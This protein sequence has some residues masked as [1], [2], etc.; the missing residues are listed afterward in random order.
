M[1]QVTGSS[2]VPRKDVV[3]GKDVVIGK[4]V[5]SN[6]A[7]FVAKEVKKPLEGSTSSLLGKQVPWHLKA[8]LKASDPVLELPKG[9]AKAVALPPTEEPAEQPKEEQPTIVSSEFNSKGNLVLTFSD[10]K[11]IAS[12]NNAPAANSFSPAAPSAVIKVNMINL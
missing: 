8:L 9:I 6:S 4:V 12:K 11:K 1:K 7:S 10:G 2:I 5:T 3:T